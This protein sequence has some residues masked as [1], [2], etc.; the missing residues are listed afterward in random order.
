MA[1]R[2]LVTGGSGTTGSLLAALLRADGVSVTTTTRGEAGPDAVRFDWGDPAS[3]PGALQGVA[4]VYVVAPTDRADQLPVMRPFLEL[5]VERVTG[6]IV[7]LSAMSLP[8]G[9][10]MMGAAHAWLRDHAPRWA[11]LR[12]SWFMQNFVGQHLR[13][14]LA[15]GSLY[16]ATGGGRV[17]FIDAADIAA[18]AAVALRSPERA[19]GELVLTGPAALT[20]DEVAAMIG[21]VARRPVRHRALTVAAL[22]ERYRTAGPPD[23]YAHLLAAMDGDIADS[24]GHA[25]TDTVSRATGR[26]PTSLETFLARNQASFSAHAGG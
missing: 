7:L 11:A 18:V 20:Y 12:P 23:D 26:P 9:G 15:E 21:R 5:T 6:P 16:S 17:P 22:A 3:F 14:I 4:A 1:E 25:P 24:G 8:P 19:S 2:V 10:P 13:A